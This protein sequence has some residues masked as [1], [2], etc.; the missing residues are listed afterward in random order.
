MDIDVL[1][2]QIKKYGNSHMILI[3]TKMMK[4]GGYSEGDVVKVMIRKKRE[5]D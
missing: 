5:D 1:Y 2:S 3:P 4:F